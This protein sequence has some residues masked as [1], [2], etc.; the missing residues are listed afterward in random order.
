M[1]R[2]ITSVVLVML[3]SVSF[4]TASTSSSESPNEVVE[5]AVGLLAKGLDERRKELKNNPQELYDFIDG[6]LLPRFER[7]VAAIAVLGPY[8]RQATDEQRKPPGRESNT[9]TL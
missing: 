3:A 5:D 1:F 4:A 8:W 6:I 2:V 9:T 7:R